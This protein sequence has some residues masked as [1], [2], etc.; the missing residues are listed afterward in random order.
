MMLVDCGEAELVQRLAQLGEVVVRV[1]DAGHRGR[2]V[3]AGRDGVEAVAGVVLAAVG[4]ARPEHQHERLVARLEHRQHDLGCDVGHVGLLRDIGRRG[5]RR[6]GVAGLAVFAARGRLQRQVGLGQRLLHFVRQRDAV[7]AAGGVVDH[8]RVQSAVPTLSVWSKMQ[9]RAELADGGGAEALL[10]RHLQNGFL[11]Q[12]VAVEMLVDVGKHRID[13]EE[14]RH[15]VVGVGD[16]MAGIDRVAEGAGIAEVMAAR[17]RR[18]VRHGEGR[19]QRMRVLEVD[20]LVAQLP[21]SRARSAASRCAR[22]GRPARTGSGCA[23][24]AFCADAAPAATR[25]GR[26]TATRLCGASDSPP[27]EV[28][29]GDPPVAPV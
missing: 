20:A 23:G 29:P 5:A 9:G 8:D 15:G 18:A 25:S 12:I 7:L 3:D 19:K 14:R 4:I 16:G 1:L 24:V 2:S 6:L 17:H 27:H 22:A 13:L 10:A 21:P 26:R 11:V 28:S